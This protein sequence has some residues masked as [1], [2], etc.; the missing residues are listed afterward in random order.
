MT[1]E[2]F[3]EVFLKQFGRPIT[4]HE[5]MRMMCVCVERKKKKNGEL[6]SKLCW[7]DEPYDCTSISLCSCGC[8]ALLTAAC[9]VYRDKNMRDLFLKGHYTKEMKIETKIEID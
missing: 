5:K 9:T 2:R 4:E 6:C 3:H 7:I 8:R 1:S